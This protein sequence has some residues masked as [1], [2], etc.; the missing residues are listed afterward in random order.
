MITIFLFLPFLHLYVTTKKQLNILKVIRSGQ[1]FRS[2]GHKDRA[3]RCRLWLGPARLRAA[4]GLLLNSRQGLPTRW[5]CR[6]R[7]Q[8]PVDAPDMEAMV[9]FGEDPDMLPCLKVWKADCA[10]RVSSIELQPSWVD[11]DRHGSEGLPPHPAL[12]K[13]RHLVWFRAHHHLARAPQCTPNN[14]VEPKS[15]D[16]CTQKNSQDHDDVCIEVASWSPTVCGRGSI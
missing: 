4:R 2:E 14:G 13:P 10:H 6:P 1:T 3:S 11:Q 15:A 16:Q 5:A 8:P 12:S 9:A 7:Q